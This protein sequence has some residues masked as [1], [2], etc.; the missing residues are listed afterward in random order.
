MSFPQTK[1][2][3]TQLF[4]VVTDNVGNGKET[5]RWGRREVTRHLGKYSMGSF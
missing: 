2:Q 3:L 5:E 1:K 4:T